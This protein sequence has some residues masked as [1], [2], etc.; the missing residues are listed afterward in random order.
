M[1]GHLFQWCCL[2]SA[3]GK[4]LLFC[5]LT[6]VLNG[7]GRMVSHG[8]FPSHI[9]ARGGNQ[10]ELNRTNKSAR[11]TLH[12]HS[13]Y[14]FWPLSCC[15][16]QNHKKTIKKTSVLITIWMHWGSYWKCATK[17][18]Y[19]SGL[20]ELNVPVAS[21]SLLVDWVKVRSVV[22]QPMRQSESHARTERR[23]STHS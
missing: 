18:M 4:E 15:F 2:P 20:N 23:Q 21:S 7:K 17:N 3:F 13:G 5:F 10:N 1:V 11:T 19:K 12:R 22:I 16:F 9:V 8:T 6:F 14:N